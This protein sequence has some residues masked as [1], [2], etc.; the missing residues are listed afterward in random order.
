MSYVTGIK[1]KLKAWDIRKSSR[2]ILAGAFSFSLWGLVMLLCNYLEIGGAGI[3]ATFFFSGAVCGGLLG[4]LLRKNVGLMAL[5]GGIGFLLYF[6]WY[7]V[8]AIAAGGEFGE[9]Y[10]WFG[11]FILILL[12]G[13]GLGALLGIAFKSR[14]AV[15]GMSLA[16]A[17]GFPLG[18]WLST[19]LRST[20]M[21]HVPMA[22]FD[23]YSPLLAWLTYSVIGIVGGAAMGAV[24]GFLERRQILKLSL[25]WG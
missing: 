20:I 7:F 24:L 14:W 19:A 21:P 1:K 10:G 17:I 16:G 12:W 4:V 2:I 18:W 25:R 5:L 23:L 13:A 8:G 3:L 15:Y 6:G 22:Q 11:L 9:P